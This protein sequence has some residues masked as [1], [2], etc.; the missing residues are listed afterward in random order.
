MVTMTSSA[1]LAESAS[2]GATVTRGLSALGSSAGTLVYHLRAVSSAQYE[3]KLVGDIAT[4]TANVP[5]L[6]TERVDLGDAFAEWADESLAIAHQQFAV[7]SS[8]WP[9]Y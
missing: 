2:P 8:S 5:V 7:V 3:W 6:E 1:L 9:T 4:A